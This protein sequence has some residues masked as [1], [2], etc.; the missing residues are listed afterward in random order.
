[1]SSSLVFTDKRSNEAYKQLTDSSRSTKRFL[2]IKIK[3]E[4]SAIESIT[5]QAIGGQ[6]DPISQ[7]HL[8]LAIS[9]AFKVVHENGIKV[10][11]ALEELH[12]FFVKFGYKG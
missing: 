7:T 11:K 2:T 10:E 5:G 1:M 6:L 12:Y 4:R 9:V 3:E 8:R